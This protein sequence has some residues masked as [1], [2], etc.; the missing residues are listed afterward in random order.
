MSKT[1]LQKDWERRIS[2]FKA[3]GQTQSK[4]CEANDLKLHQFKYWYYKIE[5]NKTT[6]APST[7]WVSVSVEDH[8]QEVNE[9]LQIKVGQA[10][11][12]IKPDFNPSF[13]SDVCK[14]T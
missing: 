5:N 3:S 9:T 7:K 4:W 6:P 1:E 2:L 14:G 12:E 11:I 13:L 8:T 10:I